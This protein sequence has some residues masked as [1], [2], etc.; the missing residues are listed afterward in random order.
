MPCNEFCG[1]DAWGCE[2]KWS[3]QVLGKEESK[4]DN[5]DN[6]CNE[7]KKTYMENI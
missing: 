6:E 4:D 1:C 2:N 3:E 7:D 5:K